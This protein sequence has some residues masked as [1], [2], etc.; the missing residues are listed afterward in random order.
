MNVAGLPVWLRVIVITLIGACLLA[1]WKW[2]PRNAAELK[3]LALSVEAHRYDWYALPAV[4]IVFVV[5]GLLLV[6]V[7]L[8]VAATGIAFGPLLGPVYAMAGC[9][10]SASVGFGIGRAMGL[11][12][13]RAF[14]GD[15]L[16][17]VARALNR[18]GT[19]AVFLIRKVP[20]PFTLVN[21]FIGAS[22]VQYREFMIGTLLGMAA[23]VVG[24]AGFGYQATE[25]FRHPEPRTLIHAAMFLAVPLTIALVINH[26]LRTRS[27]G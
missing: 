16:A 13:V 24:L 4:M 8:L 19:L 12:R 21:I 27:D 2:T 23:F 11:K 6:P 14:E 5:L 22:T 15:R 18:N 3:A 9:L 1:A 20:V 10:A 26:A 7:M 25:V 17:R